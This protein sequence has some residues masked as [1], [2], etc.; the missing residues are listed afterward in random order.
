MGTGMGSDAGSSG[1]RKRPA[2]FDL[3]CSLEDLYNGARRKMK[4]TRT[5]STLKRDTATVLE[6]NVKPGWKAG[7]KVTFASGGD[8]I[9]NTGQAQDVV[10]VIRERRHRIYMRDGSNLLHHRPIP[11]VDALTGFEFEIP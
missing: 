4:V 6:V 7:T 9:G 2:V 1:Q 11:L 10:F 5:S 3:D 8:E